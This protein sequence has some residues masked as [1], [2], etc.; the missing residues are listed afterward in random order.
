MSVSIKFD[1]RELERSLKKLGSLRAAEV[2]ARAAYAGGEVTAEE[3]KRRAPNSGLGR[4]ASRKKR[5]GKIYANKLSQDV[6]VKKAQIDQRGVLVRVVSLPYYTGMVE[7]GTSKQA[8]NPYI[9]RASRS[10]K[11]RAT[12]KFIEGVRKMCEES[13]R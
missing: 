5:N 13:F 11:P 8:P 4:G 9:R 1:A 12:E 3:I 7:K 6:V 2:L 10:V